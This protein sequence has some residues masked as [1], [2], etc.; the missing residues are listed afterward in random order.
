MIHKLSRH[1]S[2]KVKN[3]E[4]LVFSSSAL[5]RHQLQDC[6]RE[7]SNPKAFVLNRVRVLIS[8]R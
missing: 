5:I 8:S 3:K 2:F 6:G 4:T 7:F 1:Y